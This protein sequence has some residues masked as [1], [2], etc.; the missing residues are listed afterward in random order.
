MISERSGAEQSV[1]ER[2]GQER[3]GAERRR[4]EQCGVE[5]KKESSPKY[6]NFVS[7]QPHIRIV[8]RI[9]MAQK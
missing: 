4:T 8:K 3:S 6:S 7:K 5:R 9:N 2:S 1:Q